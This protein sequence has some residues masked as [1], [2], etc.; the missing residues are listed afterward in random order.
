MFRQVLRKSGRKVTGKV[1]G[2][3]MKAPAVRGSGANAGA[4]ASAHPLY[5]LN[6]LRPNYSDEMTQFVLHIARDCDGVGDFLAQ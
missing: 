2:W 3:V 1:V 6:F 5:C 4:G